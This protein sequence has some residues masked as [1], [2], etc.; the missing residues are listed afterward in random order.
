MSHKKNSYSVYNHF[1]IPE[2]ILK[3]S[4]V[5]LSSKSTR[6]KRRKIERI[7]KKFKS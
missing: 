4:V 6:N 1:K 7:I 3:K 5:L 2:T